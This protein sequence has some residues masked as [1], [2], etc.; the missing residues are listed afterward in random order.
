VEIETTRPELLAACVALVAN[1]GDGRYRELVGRE[2]LTPLFRARVPVVAHPL[3]D[4]EKGS[5]LAMVCTFGDTTDVVWWRELGLPARVVVGRDGLLLPVSW[6]PGG[7]ASEDPAAAREAYDQLAGLTVR[8]ARSRVVELLAGAGSLVREPRPVTHA[9]KFYERG[10]RPLEI[11]T[12][13]QWFIRTVE[14]RAELLARGEEL[15]WHPSFMSGRYRSWVEGLSGDWNISRQ[16]WFGVPFPVWYEVRDDGTVDHDRPLLPAEERLPLD[17]STEAPSGFDEAE[18]GRPG[19]FAGDPDVMDTWATSSL[20]PQ[21]VGGWEEDPDLFSRVFPMDLRPQGQDIIRTWLFATVVRSHLE[22]H[23]LP[24][25]DAA[26]SGWILDP[27]RKKMSKSKGKVVTPMALLERYGSDAVRYW[28]ASGRP[29]MD[30]AFDE[31]Q[32]KIGRRLATKLLNA[33]RFVLS[34]AGPAGGAGGG[35][36]GGG[37]LL[38]VTEPVDRGLLGRLAKVVGEA[39]SAFDRYDYARALERTEAFFWSFCDDYLELVKARAYGGDG[40]TAT[41]TASGTGTASVRATLAVALSVVQRLF[42]PFLPFVAEEVWSWWQD[43][44][45]H[46]AAWPA[47]AELDPGTAPYGATASEPDLPDGEAALRLASEVLGHVRRAKS[48]AH[49]SMRAPVRSVLVTGGPGVEEG[50]RAAEGDLRAAGGVT[51]PVHVRAVAGAG[52][53]LRTVEVTLDRPE[54]PAGGPPL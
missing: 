39:T 47:A 11:V 32:M 34:L 29:G 45:V 24:W 52:A 26:V 31:G 53:T 2:V 7:W 6:G 44:S 21:I 51:G 41:G 16:R 35:G 42:A 8:R 14:H 19:G 15:A 43:G 27:D 3:A 10:E 23:C 9:V 46:R 4:P 20:S 22:Q 33:S 54:A 17:P 30:A 37:P 40:A 13:R 1:P 28:A 18:R 48:E 36:A 38:A 12:S 50:L 49:L 25:S 5:G